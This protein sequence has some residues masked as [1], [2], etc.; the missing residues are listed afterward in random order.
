MTL[1]RSAKLNDC[2]EFEKPYFPSDKYRACL[3]HIA[4]DMLVNEV[5]CKR[6][7]IY[8]IE[9]L[10]DNEPPLKFYYDPDRRL[11]ISI[12]VEPSSGFISIR[13]TIQRIE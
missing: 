3:I 10:Y 9:N 7:Y 13:E 6:C 1:L 4:Q 8:T 2:W 11:M 5:L 12:S